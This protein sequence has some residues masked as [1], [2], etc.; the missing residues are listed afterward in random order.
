MLTYLKAEIAGPQDQKEGGAPR[1]VLPP[2]L[3]D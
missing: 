1:P 3:V 2:N